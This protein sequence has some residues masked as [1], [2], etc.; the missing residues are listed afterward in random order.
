MKFY[1][2]ENE[3]KDCMELKR[4]GQFYVQSFYENYMAS[5]KS[6]EQTLRGH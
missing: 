1:A 4:K 2:N 5:H 3:S 6:K